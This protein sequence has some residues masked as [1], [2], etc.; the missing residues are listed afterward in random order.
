MF[1]VVI[2]GAGV[3]GVSCALVLGSAQNKP[4]A[5]DKKIAII[6][7]Q[8]ASSLQNAVFNNA[9]AECVLFEPEN[10][11]LTQPL[12]NPISPDQVNNNDFYYIYTVENFLKLVNS[13]LLLVYNKIVSA[14]PAEDWTKQLAPKFIWD[15]STNTMNLLLTSAFIEGL[16]TNTFYISFN[17]DLMNLFDTFP[18]V[19]LS[20]TNSFDIGKNFVFSILNNYSYNSYGYSPDGGTTFY[21]IHKFQQQSSSVPS[22]SPVSEILF[23]T[24]NIPIEPEFVGGGQ[25]L[26]PNL[27]SSVS[28][29]NAS[30]VMTSFT[31]PLLSGVE[32]SKALLYYTP[33]SEYR[34]VDLI[35]DGA[36]LNRLTMT[37][38]W[39][40]KLGF[41]HLMTL[42]QG[43]NATVK[44]LFRKKIF[45]GV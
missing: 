43:A 19:A 26:G 37:I 28:Q 20:Y 44:C 6:A 27:K 10:L 17:T 11:Y 15:T 7:H 35:A 4:F 16:T 30:S 24:N 22:W 18:N 12:F 42:K 5:V 31:I 2:I 38:F 41:S 21:T 9:D 36:V 13:A 3:S 34:L 39:K 29:Q 1:D 23:T 14:Y 32:Y 25:Y 8:K 45:N 40:D 33:T